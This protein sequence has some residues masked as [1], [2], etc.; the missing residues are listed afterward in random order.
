MIL[1]YT[2]CLHFQTC[3]LTVCRS[4]PWCWSECRSYS[5]KRRLGVKAFK[6]FFP[7]FLQFD[8]CPACLAF[9]QLNASIAIPTA[10][11]DKRAGI[12]EARHN[13]VLPTFTYS[14]LL[15]PSLNLFLSF[16]LSIL[17]FHLSYVKTTNVHF[18]LFDVWGRIIF[19]LPKHC[20]HLH[21][22]SS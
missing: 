4:R 8:M 22:I 15:Q 1:N 6:G 16:C 7:A 13:L 19:L 10:N 18:P 14:L 9:P 5:V 21:Y 11:I 12:I 17:S 2:P 20:W 3:E